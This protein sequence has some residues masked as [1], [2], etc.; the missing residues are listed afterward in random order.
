MSSYIDRMNE[1]ISKA[2]EEAKQNK[3][4]KL[5]MSD[6]ETQ[7]AKALVDL[8]N[9]DSFKKFIELENDEIGSLMANAFK[10]VESDLVNFG[11]KMAFNKGRYEQMLSFRQRREEMVKR[12]IYIIE[13][14]G[15]KKGD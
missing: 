2:R 14:E 5:K 6:R 9:N 4:K 8:M 1:V 10:Y 3:V 12:Y 15:I 7:I 13:N 11:E